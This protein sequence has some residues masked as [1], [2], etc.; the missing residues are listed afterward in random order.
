MSG[1]ARILF[2]AT[3]AWSSVGFAAGGPSSPVQFHSKVAE[4]Y[5]FEP[6]KL[7]EAEMKAKSDQLDQFWNMVKADAAGMLPLLRKELTNT[8]NPSFFFYDGSKLLLSLSTEQGDR[9]VAL[10]AIPRADLRGVDHSD[11]LRTVQ[12]LAS[13]GLDTRQA[14]FRILSYPDFKAFIPQHALTLGQ[15]YS[16]IYMLFPMDEKLFLRDLID[17]LASEKEPTAQKSL[18]L[19]LWYASI[20]E[21]SL[22]LENFAKR[23]D[24]APNVVAYAKDLLNKRRTF[25]SA[26]PSGESAL[27][28]ERRR[29]MRRPISDEALIEFDKLTAKLFAK[30]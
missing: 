16:L 1:I 4:L 30:Q 12:S 28:D 18:L 2:T 25:A 29:V 20:S 19:A 14:A 21:G 3:I 24:V 15:N 23:P 10:A 6:Q 22:A 5:N 27:R 17:R 8:Q 11:Y 13:N 7:G 26:S 9:M